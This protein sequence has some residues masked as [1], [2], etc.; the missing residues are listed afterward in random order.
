MTGALKQLNC[1]L[2]GWHGHFA[3]VHIAN[4]GRMPVLRGRLEGVEEERGGEPRD[5]EE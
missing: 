5:S 3:H 1:K 4:T 2:F